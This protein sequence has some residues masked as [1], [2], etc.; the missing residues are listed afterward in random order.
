MLDQ[1][2]AEDRAR[3]GSRTA[4]CRPGADGATTLRF[5]IRLGIAKVGNTFYSSHWTDGPAAFGDCKLA[6]SCS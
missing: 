5:G 2:A 6:E 1:P 4:Q 3:G